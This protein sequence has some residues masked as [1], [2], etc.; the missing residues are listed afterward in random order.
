V[1]LLNSN[2]PS[3][4]HSAIQFGTHEDEWDQLDEC[5]E[6]MSICLEVGD[7]FV[8]NA[9]ESN[10]ED[11]NFYFVLCTQHVHIVAKDFTNPWKT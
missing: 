11:V 3:Y 4:V 10:E 9:E 5:G 8:V 6:Y 2:N 7:N 1:E